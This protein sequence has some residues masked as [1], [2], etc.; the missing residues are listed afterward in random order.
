MSKYMNLNE[1]QMQ[2][3]RELLK[4]LPSAHEV[5]VTV[6]IDGQDKWFEADWLYALLRE[7]TDTEPPTKSSKGSV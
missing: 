5:D 4:L 7:V 1:P 2:T 3:I 6:R